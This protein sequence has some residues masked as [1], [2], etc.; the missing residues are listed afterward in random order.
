MAAMCCLS[1]RTATGGHHERGA[2]QPVALRYQTRDEK[3]AQAPVYCG[4]TSLLQSMWRVAAARGLAVRLEFLAAHATAG[5][6][7][8]QLAAQLRGDIAA[9]L[10]LSLDSASIQPRQVQSANQFQLVGDVA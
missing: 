2:G 10:C 8:R 1:W 4:E 7:R 6:E 9:A 5:L 3:P